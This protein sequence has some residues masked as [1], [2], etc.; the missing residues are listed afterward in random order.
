[1]RHDVNIG[2]G[3]AVRKNIQDTVCTLQLQ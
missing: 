3:S 2:D 1:L